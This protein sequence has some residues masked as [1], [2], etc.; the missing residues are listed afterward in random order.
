VKVLPLFLGIV[1]A[2]G[3]RNMPSRPDQEPIDTESAHVD[4]VSIQVRIQYET[5]VETLDRTGREVEAG[6]HVVDGPPV[7]EWYGKTLGGLGLVR[8]VTVPHKSIGARNRDRDVTK[9]HILAAL[10]HYTLVD[11]EDFHSS[12][13]IPMGASVRIEY[14]NGISG[15]VNF[16]GGVPYTATLTR[17]NSRAKYGL[18]RISEQ[19]APADAKN[20]AAKP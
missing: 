1:L 11:Y 9:K 13:H 19:P 16:F 6:K 5:Q 4:D 17:N 15:W 2:V 14:R 12:T 7:K 20:R 10:A 8:I 18:S 3:C